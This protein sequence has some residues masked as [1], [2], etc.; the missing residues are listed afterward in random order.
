MDK[1]NAYVTQLFKK[2]KSRSPMR[3]SDELELVRGNGISGDRAYGQTRRQILLTS[4]EAVTDLSLAP[5]DLRENITISGL[6][7]DELKPGQKIQIGDAVIESEGEC[8]SCERLEDIRPGLIDEV[9]GKRGL[10]A[11]V[12][13]GGVIRVNDPVSLKD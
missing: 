8:T 5:G 4:L 9:R 13:T 6:N 10:L 12:V 2:K 7:V 3:S 1:S 11:R